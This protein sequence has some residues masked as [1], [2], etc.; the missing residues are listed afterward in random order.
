ME[1][2]KKMNVP[3][4]F[5]YKTIIDSVLHDIKQSTD[6]V[7]TEE[8]LT[9][10]SYVKQFSKDSQAT[11]QIDDLKKNEMYAFHT[12]TKRNAFHVTYKIETIDENNCT[13]Y[14][15][16]KMTS[17]GMIQQL[18]DMVLGTILGYFKRKQFK[19]MLVMMEESY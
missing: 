5:L 13:L 8:Q 3:A 12:A 16:E 11:I 6:K 2:T 14:Y 9:G 18:N 19:K 15:E 7:L 4:A 1:I 10:Y 17:E